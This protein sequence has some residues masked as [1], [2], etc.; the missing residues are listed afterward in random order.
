MGANRYDASL[1]TLLFVE[2][3]RAFRPTHRRGAKAW[4]KS[5]THIPEDY[6]S[7]LIK[8]S[9][10]ISLTVSTGHR[11]DNETVQNTFTYA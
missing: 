5:F 8:M 10:K 4:P 3:V 1:L 9:S 6:A 7:D 2:T 11:M